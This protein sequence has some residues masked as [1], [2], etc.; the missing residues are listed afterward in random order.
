MWVGVYIRV[1]PSTDIFQIKP[2]NAKV[3]DPVPDKATG[4]VQLQLGRQY[5]ACFNAK[6]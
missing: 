6:E 5:T 4:A 2:C 1:P 3:Q